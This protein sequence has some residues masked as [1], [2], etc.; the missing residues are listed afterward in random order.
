MTA[1]FY[2]SLWNK[3]PCDG[4]TMICPILEWQ[5]FTLPDK[6][7]ANDQRF[8]LTIK[9]DNYAFPYLASG[10][11][12][13]T[14]GP[15][16]STERDWPIATIEDASDNDLV[17][18][19]ALSVDSLTTN[20]GVITQTTGGVTTALIGTE[21]RTFVGFLDQRF[22]PNASA[23]GLGWILSVGVNDATDDQIVDIFQITLN[24]MNRGQL[25]KQLT[26]KSGTT[27]TYERNARVSYG[28]SFYEQPGAS[29]ASILLSVGRQI[30]SLSR[31][32]DLLPTFTDIEPTGTAGDSMESSLID[33]AWR[34]VSLTAAGGGAYWVEL[35]D[36]DPLAP[37]TA[38]PVLEAAQFGAAVGGQSTRLRLIDGTFL[39]ITDSRITPTNSVKVGS[40]GALVVDDRVE[41]VQA[42]SAAAPRRL[43]SPSARTAYTRARVL[44]FPTGIP[45]GH[46]NWAENALFDTWSSAN[47]CSGWTASGTMNIT[48]VPTAAPTTLSAL[49]NGAMSAS[50]AVVCDNCTSGAA[51]YDGEN[52]VINGTTKIVA[53]DWYESGGTISFNITVAHTAPDNSVVTFPGSSLRVATWPSDKQ[54]YAMWLRSSSGNAQPPVFATAHIGSR[55]ISVRY[56]AGL[57]K[58]NAAAEFTI[59]NNNG[60]TIGN[61]DAGVA[62]TDDV[63]QISATGRTLPAIMIVNTGTST[64]LATATVPTR[65][66]NLTDSSQ[67]IQCSA[68]LAADTTCKIALVGQNSLLST[69]RSHCNW[70]AMWL[71]ASD[72][73]PPAWEGSRATKIWRRGHQR[74]LLSLTDT[75]YKVEL[76][77][78]SAQSIVLGGPAIVHDQF[79]NI[80]AEVRILGVVY[81]DEKMDVPQSIEIAGREQDLASFLAAQ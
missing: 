17:K 77:D 28:I 1:R 22:F 63:T 51:L 4:G 14:E 48:K 16:G 59:R 61:F 9:R 53:G 40:L 46:R 37:S 79:R 13:V 27:A 47:A 49:L 36:P 70:V 19:S 34:I 42:G 43:I 7:G 80:K 45:Y 23:D 8:E 11:V 60:A 75:R 10:L 38:G 24:N 72:D 2:V 55:P 3:L 32:R 76:A 20:A 31:V 64:A 12:L 6:L 33:N 26:D 21:R 35:N 58:L 73:I 66:A 74:L 54:T 18:I 69:V 78:L 56:L 81:T 5:S 52:V 71:G 29:S 57:A 65:I 39:T 62:I 41:I 68:T 67:T 44:N 30:K 15:D 50:T 25:L